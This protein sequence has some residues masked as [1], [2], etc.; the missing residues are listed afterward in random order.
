M[1][2]KKLQLPWNGND[3]TTVEQKE[4]IAEK[5]KKPITLKSI[6]LKRLVL[7]F[8]SGVLL[9]LLCMPDSFLED[10]TGTKK[11]KETQQEERVAE[12]ETSSGEDYVSR[13]ENRLKAI[14]SKVEGAGDVEVMI[15]LS[16][17]S[18]K[19]A[20]K[21]APYSSDSVEETDSAGGI[22]KSESYSGQE[23]TILVDG[24][25]GGETPYII[26]EVEP[27]IEG[28]VVLSG[29]GDDASLQKEIIDA[30]QVLF[31]VPVHKIKVMKHN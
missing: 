19:V 7:L 4:E 20:L 24:E 9:L 11:K 27:R 6:G 16:E 30:V 28:V 10:V 22:R 3:E 17:S 26:K 31:D 21:D 15:T 5:K 18:E 2:W 1:D 14:L 13:M 25:E 23:T 12:E 29:N 8:G